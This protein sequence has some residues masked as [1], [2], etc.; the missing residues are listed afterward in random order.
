[1]KIPHSIKL[2]NPEFRKLMLMRLLNR[3]EIDDITLCWNYKGAIEHEGYGQVSIEAVD[4]RVHRVSAYIY[5]ILE[6]LSDDSKQILHKCNNKKYWNSYHIYS[7]TYADNIR[8]RG[9]THCING[10]PYSIYGYLVRRSRWNPTKNRKCKLCIRNRNQ[11]RKQ[12]NE[13]KRG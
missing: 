9:K 5:G 7:G 8:D 4:F 6:F 13:T 2:S 1:M 12:Q 10:H 3:T 11:K